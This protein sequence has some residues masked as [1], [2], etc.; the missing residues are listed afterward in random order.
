MPKHHPF[1]IR[2]AREASN[3]VRRQVIGRRVAARE[4]AL[5]YEHIRIARES[6]EF[7]VL[8]RV[9]GVD[10]RLAFRLDAIADGRLGMSGVRRL[11]RPRVESGAC[12]A[13][14][15]NVQRVRLRRDAGK[16]LHQL[17]VKSLR[18]TTPAQVNWL[19]ARP[20]GR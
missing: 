8:F 1:H 20:A 6:H 10:N 17:R 18:A 2:R 15:A 5:A 16:G 13:K 7:R 3:R 9:A 11:N 4:R 14:F 19:R 12:C